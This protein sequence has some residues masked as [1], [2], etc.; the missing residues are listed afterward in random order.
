MQMKRDTRERFSGSAGRQ[1]GQSIPCPSA[2]SSLSS[3]SF[4]T[5]RL[6]GYHGHTSEKGHE[7]LRLSGPY[8]DMSP[9]DAY[10]P[11]HTT[12]RMH[13]N[14]PQARNES[15]SW[16][17]QDWHSPQAIGPSPD[18]HVGALS[19]CLLWSARPMRLL[20]AT[21]IAGKQRVLTGKSVL[22]GCISLCCDKSSDEHSYQCRSVPVR[23]LSTEGAFD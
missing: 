2:E 17:L 11:L 6:R 8:L 9:K 14:V 1:P 23:G 18:R 10:L 4:H 7:E 3:M 19:L 22:V 20:C 21:L 15:V 13:S 5:V 16:P 12:R